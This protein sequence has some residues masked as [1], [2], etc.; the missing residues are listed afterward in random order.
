MSLLRL[1]NP[2]NEVL[3][4]TYIQKLNNLERLKEEEEGNLDSIYYLVED[5][6]ELLSYYEYKYR[7]GILSSYT[8][9][10]A[11]ALLGARQL[12]DKDEINKVLTKEFNKLPVNVKYDRLRGL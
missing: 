12:T 5:C 10:Y 11:L 1:T 9:E 3:V 2:E 7:L 6:E 4:N 8:P